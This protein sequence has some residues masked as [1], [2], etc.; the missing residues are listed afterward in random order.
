MAFMWALEMLYMPDADICLSIFLNSIF[1]SL[2]IR[3]MR[4]YAYRPLDC[5]STLKN[6]LRKMLTNVPSIIFARLEGD[7]NSSEL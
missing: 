7:K 5:E 3:I 4:I 1:D 2:K 6:S